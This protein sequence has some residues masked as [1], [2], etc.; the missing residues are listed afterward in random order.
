[1]FSNDLSVSC[2]KKCHFFQW[3]RSVKRVIAYSISGLGK[4]GWINDPC[5]EST[6]K[7]ILLY[8]NLSYYHLHNVLR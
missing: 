7:I 8:E 2:L 6:K 1:M 3:K 5:G 4:E